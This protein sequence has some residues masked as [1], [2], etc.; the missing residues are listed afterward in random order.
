MFW[1]SEWL[2]GSWYP[3]KE[4]VCILNVDG[5]NLGNLG[6]SGMRGLIRNANGDW[7][8]GFTGFLGIHDNLFVEIMTL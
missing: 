6:K 8:I 2:L 4:N 7:I 1:I 3:S 5:S